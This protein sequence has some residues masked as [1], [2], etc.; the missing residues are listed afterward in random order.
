MVDFIE[1]DGNKGYVFD[2]VFFCEGNP[3]VQS[4]LGEC[5]TMSNVQNTRLDSLRSKLAD[6]VKAKGGNALIGFKYVQ[7]AT[8]FSL[9]SVRWTASGT[10]AIIDGLQDSVNKS[11]SEQ[12]QSS[13][14]NCPFCNEEID[15]RA[16]KC[17][18]CQEFLS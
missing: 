15:A 7:K 11:K 2:G 18:Y 14:K 1:I 13:R 12:M 16:I 10:A 17:R 9:S 3:K 8:V 5:S 6:Q 4:V